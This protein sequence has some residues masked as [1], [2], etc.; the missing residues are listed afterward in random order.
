M[1]SL[2][3]YPL[4]ISVVGVGFCFFMDLWLIL[5]PPPSPLLRKGPYLQSFKNVNNDVISCNISPRW[6]HFNGNPEIISYWWN[7]WFWWD[8]W[9]VLGAGRASEPIWN[10]TSE[11]PHSE[12][13]RLGL[14]LF[15]IYTHPLGEPSRLHG[16]K[17]HIC[18][19]DIYISP[20]NPH[21]DNQVSIVISN[22]I[23]NG[24]L[25]FHVI[26]TTYLF[27]RKSSVF[28]RV[29]SITTHLITH[30]KSR[31]FLWLFYFIYATINSMANAGN[32]I[33][34]RT[35]TTISLLLHCS[36]PNMS[37]YCP[38][39]RPLLYPHLIFLIPVSLKFIS[40]RTASLMFSE[41]QIQSSH[42]ST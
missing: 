6:T 42:S 4:R 7:L 33:F 8:W 17:C 22:W 1:P 32:F 36:Y 21:L 5:F 26:K 41:T 35:P 25:H 20:G 37:H 10:Q 40:H 29:H 13:T 23:S 15:C 14:F 12:I 24:N 3:S 19:E 38:L 28:F 34:K 9:Q 39:P 30:D 2:P 18:I 16:F 31:S 11:L 27:L